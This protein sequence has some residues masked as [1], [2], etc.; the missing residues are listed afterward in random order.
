MIDLTIVYPIDFLDEVRVTLGLTSDDLYDDEI[1]SLSLAGAAELDLISLVPNVK[2]ILEANNTEQVVIM[3]LTL[4]MINLVAY[5]AY[6]T[7]KTNL[8]LTESDNKTFGT[9]F[10]DA[11]SRDRNEFKAAA[12][13]SL[14]I[15]GITPATSDYDRISISTPDIDIITGNEYT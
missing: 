5:Y 14:D 3:Q 15:I 8:L 11:L 12:M 1:M 4:A 13:R 10:K 6:P 7:L 2:S 9:R